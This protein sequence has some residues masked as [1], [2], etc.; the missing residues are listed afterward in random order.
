MRPTIAILLLI[1]ALPAC[2]G[3]VYDD[4]LVSRE[5]VHV[6]LFEF[7][8]DE[9]RVHYSV[10]WEPIVSSGATWGGNQYVNYLSGALAT[11]N[12]PGV[13]F[14]FYPFQYSDLTDVGAHVFGIGSGQGDFRL[15]LLWGLISLGR[16]WNFFYLN[17]FWFGHGDPMYQ[18]APDE[19]R[20]EL[21][22][23]VVGPDGA[24]P[25]TETESADDAEPDAEVEG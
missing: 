25:A 4:G 8:R 11:V 15:S 9:S 6:G 23:H 17:G 10:L 12:I 16:E 3:R 18:G 1:C 24:E 14:I 19:V 20:D 5:Q 13:A 21:A 2:T 7:G 22:S